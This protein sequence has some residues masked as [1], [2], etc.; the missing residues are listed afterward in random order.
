MVDKLIILYLCSF[1]FAKDERV[2]PKKIDY[3][4]WKVVNY[5]G[6]TWYVNHKDIIGKNQEFIKGWAEGIFFSCQGG[7]SSTYTSYS[8]EEFLNNKEFD[9]FNKIDFKSNKGKIFVHRI[10]CF[11]KENSQI[12]VLYPLVSQQNSNQIYYL[13]E[14]AIYILE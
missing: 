12:K 14:G 8:V 6:E 10:S 2:Y 3:K 7:R 1:L 13:F 9:L 4:T 11:E 5:V